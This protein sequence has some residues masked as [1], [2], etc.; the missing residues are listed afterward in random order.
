MKLSE[1]VKNYRKKH[2]LSLRQLAK[3]CECSYQY[4]S[5]LENDEIAVPT[6]KTL[7]NLAMGMG[8]SFHELLNTVDDM[9]MYYN[10][11]SFTKMNR[12]VKTI[13][14]EESA[15]LNAYTDADERAKKMVRMLLGIEQ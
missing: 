11:S 10:A 4:L 6:A 2:G 9:D 7:A 15:L 8:M 3:R 13:S 1:Y 14:E 5:K 12:H